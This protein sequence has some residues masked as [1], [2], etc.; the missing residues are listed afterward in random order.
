MV[1][2]NL[3]LRRI[4]IVLALLHVLPLAL[5][6]YCQITENDASADRDAILGPPFTLLKDELER[7]FPREEVLEK[8]GSRIAAEYPSLWYLM[9]TNFENKLVYSFFKEGA[10]EYA[11]RLQ[12]S[13]RGLNKFSMKEGT[14]YREFEGNRTMVS[15]EKLVIEMDTYYFELGFGP[16]R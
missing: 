9:I 3:K 10:R 8:W 13:F 6:A 4:A 7:S 11:S 5:P 14:S 1:P 15:H 12:D 16:I 2:I